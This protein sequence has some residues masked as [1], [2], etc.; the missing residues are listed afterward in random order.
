M[1]ATGRPLP[2]PALN[3]PRV[4]AGRYVDVAREYVLAC[5]HAPANRALRREAIAWFG[6]LTTHYLEINDL[7]PEAAA[8]FHS[9]IALAPAFPGQAMVAE[10]LDQGRV[11]EVQA[12]LD[13]A[14]QDIREQ[15]RHWADGIVGGTA[16]DTA[17]VHAKG[18]PP[19]H[20]VLVSVPF[21]GASAIVPVVKDYV[22]ALGFVHATPATASAAAGALADADARGQRVFAWFH[23]P[24]DEMGACLAR[25]DI[26]L[27]VLHRDPRDL[28]VSVLMAGNPT[29]RQ[30]MTAIAGY[31]LEQLA[32]DSI[33]YWQ[34]LAAA[35]PAVHMVAFDTMKAD[36]AGL[37]GRMAGAMGLPVDRERLEA[38][39][40]ANSF[41]ALTGRAQG[42]GG[43]P[44]RREGYVFRKGTSGQWR[45]VFDH[46]CA[47][48]FA[49]K[50]GPLLMAGDWEKDLAWIGA[51][52]G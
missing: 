26:S 31:R 33:P 17:G 22:E 15:A 48:R 41:E 52:K 8:C 4:R 32:V 13:A 6:L 34:A 42:A 44:L 28:I 40:R 30:A 18:P 14:A 47:H 36:I 2:H 21:S 11:A 43:P 24:H 12:I 5:A 37:A 27:F 46:A 10:A 7:P 50:Y 38:L 45:D 3:D 29:A 23:A 49:A 19:R 20:L 9:F 16:G 39:A 1:I 35:D 51:V 25:D